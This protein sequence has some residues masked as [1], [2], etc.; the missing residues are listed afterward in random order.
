[1]LE[2]QD[3]VERKEAILNE[4]IKTFERSTQPKHTKSIPESIPDN[5]SLFTIQC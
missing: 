2:E 4:K 1:M 5:G 3:L